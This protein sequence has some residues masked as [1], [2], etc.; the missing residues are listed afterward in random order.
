MACKSALF[1]PGVMEGKRNLSLHEVVVRLKEHQTV[2]TRRAGEGPEY[3]RIFTASQ[4]PCKAEAH[5]KCMQFCTSNERKIM[6]HP[7]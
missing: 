6:Q 2:L 5:S 3:G 4:Q 7:P 1:L